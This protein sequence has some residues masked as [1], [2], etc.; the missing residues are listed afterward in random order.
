MKIKL[1]KEELLCSNCGKPRTFYYLSDYSY[2]ERLV[3]INHGTG[4]AYMNMIEDAVYDDFSILLKCIL[5][6]RSIVLA[7]SDFAE[8]LSSL[9]GISCDNIGGVP[10][11]FSYN[12]EKCLSCGSV[13][14]DYELVGA[15]KIVEVDLPVITHESW[16]LKNDDEKRNAIKDLLDK[17]KS[18]RN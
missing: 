11:D 6:E 5:G 7:Q 14:F 8:V 10:I 2:G 16:N 18:A 13:K 15:E 17:F 4:Y 3:L 1:R 9:F 12:M